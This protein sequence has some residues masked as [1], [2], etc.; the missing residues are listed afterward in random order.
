MT[1]R[2]AA[3]TSRLSLMRRLACAQA[4]QAVSRQFPAPAS[5][6]TVI[7]QRSSPPCKSAR[8]GPDGVNSS[9][10]A[11]NFTSAIPT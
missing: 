3:S 9:K 8:N 7:F 6:W 4:G 5:A 2:S 1:A 11:G 10:L